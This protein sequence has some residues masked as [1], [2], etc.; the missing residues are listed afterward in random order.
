MKNN[1]EIKICGMCRSDDI[2]KADELGV[3][4]TG[5]VFFPGSSRFI[6]PHKAAVMLEGIRVS[7]RKVGVFVNQKREEIEKIT[8]DLRLDAVQLHGDETPEDFTDFPVP[9][10]RALR[11]NVQDVIIEAEKWIVDRYVVDSGSAENFGGTGAR[12]DWGKAAEF[13]RN[14]KIMLAGGLNSRN[15]REA[16]KKVLPF[17]VDAVSGVESKPGC[18][19]HDEMEKFVK[20]VRM[21]ERGVV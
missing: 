19:D 21:L 9:V 12:G 17:G 10:W 11:Q 3:E 20:A 4:Y 1:F 8:A 5:F 16:L 2:L 6:S 7:C 15:V 18:K 13:A 14:R